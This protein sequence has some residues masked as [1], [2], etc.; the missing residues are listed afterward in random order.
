VVEVRLHGVDGY[1]DT[2]AF[3][4]A[5]EPSTLVVYEINGEPLPTRHGYPVRVIAPGLFGEKSV[6]WGRGSN[7]FGARIVRLQKSIV[8]SIA[9]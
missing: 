2:F 5:M 8:R 9:W 4:K 7:S 6:K 1:T 3:A